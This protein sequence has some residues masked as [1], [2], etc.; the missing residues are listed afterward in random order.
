MATRIEQKT[1]VD[2]L[3]WMRSEDWLTFLLI[4]ATILIVVRLVEV[5]EWVETPFISFMALLG[6]LLGLLMSKSSWK[7]WQRHVSAILVGATAAYIQGT[8]LVQAKPQGRR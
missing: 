6:A 7:T 4:S 5:V 2:V 1:Q 8:G 3:R